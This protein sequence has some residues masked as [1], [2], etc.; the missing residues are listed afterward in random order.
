MGA[1]II[2]AALIKTALSTKISFKEAKAAENPYGY[3][4]RL[5]DLDRFKISDRKKLKCCLKPRSQHIKELKNPPTEFDV[6]ILGGGSTGASV[7]LECAN[8]GLYCALID[9]KDFASEASCKTSKILHGNLA[10]DPYMNNNIFTGISKLMENISERNYHLNSA[11]YMNRQIGIITPCSNIFSASYQYIKS[12]SYHMLCFINWVFS[13]YTFKLTRPKFLFREEV[14]QNFPN[15]KPPKYAVQSIEGHTLDARLVLQT[16]LTTSI[17]KY[18]NKNA[19]GA[20]LGNYIEFIDFIKDTKTRRIIG[21]KLRDKIENKEFNVKCKVIVNCTGVKTDFIRKKDNPNCIEKTVGVLENY[22]VLPENYCKYNNGIILNQGN[23]RKKIPPL[24][25]FPYEN[26]YA[27][28]GK[29]IKIINLNENSH[30]FNPDTE[31]KKLIENLKPYFSSN[32]QD[33]KLNLWTSIRPLFLNINEKPKGIKNRIFHKINQIFA[34]IPILNKYYSHE[35]YLK[36]PKIE[37]SESG[38]VSVLGGSFTGSRKKGKAA[39]KQ[40]LT[41]FK[42]IAAVP[43]KI[44]TKHIRLIGGYTNRALDDTETDSTEFVKTYTR[45]LH[46]HYGID[47]DCCYTLLRQYGATSIKVAHIGQENYLNQRIHEQVPILK[48]QVIYAIKKE[49][50]TNVK[51][52]VF[53][54]LELGFTTKEIRDEIIPAVANVMA[55]ELNWDSTKKETEIYQAQR[56]VQI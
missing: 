39:V 41:E 43:K 30:K 5:K 1:G 47:W 15:L 10:L 26:H 44:S 24:F 23:Y 38:L 42:T 21:A 9:S 25:I 3:D 52:V 12:Y 45:Y 36:E 31:I 7:L 16:L 55:T 50:A 32:L 35:K 37:I 11:P 20:I 22:I 19:K 18:L 6:L 34:K 28:A 14:Q 29:T 51:D 46:E 13:D 4:M 49:L 8:R 33:D 17:D 48:S 54:R 56:M 2:N 40:I 53:R 27:I